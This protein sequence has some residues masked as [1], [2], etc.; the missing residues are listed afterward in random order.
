VI[1]TPD[2]LDVREH[3]SQGV[4]EVVPIGVV[5]K[6]FAPDVIRKVLASA[7]MPP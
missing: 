5:S 7:R 2:D 6:E 3:A 4:E 1:E